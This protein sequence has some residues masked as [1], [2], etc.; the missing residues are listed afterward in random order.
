MYQNETDTN[1]YRNVFPDLFILTP[2][3]NLA[4]LLKSE[5]TSIELQLTQVQSSLKNQLKILS[6]TEGS[7]FSKSDS[8]GRLLKD[9]DLKPLSGNEI[10]SLTKGGWSS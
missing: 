7:P 8:P 1:A 6:E 5:Q 10:F 9:L 3:S 2:V 4:S